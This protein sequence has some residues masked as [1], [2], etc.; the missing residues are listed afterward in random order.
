MLAKQPPIGS[1][2]TIFGCPRQK[3]TLQRMS[4]KVLFRLRWSTCQNEKMKEPGRTS[5]CRHF[6]VFNGTK[7]RESRHSRLIR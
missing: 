7:C 1:T 5:G 6:R 3:G 2:N 4:A